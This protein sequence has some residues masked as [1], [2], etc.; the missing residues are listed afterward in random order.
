LPERSKAEFNILHW[1]KL[2]IPE[3]GRLLRYTG[4]QGL[5]WWDKDKATKVE[6]YTGIK[7][8]QYF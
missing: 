8:T 1:D 5:W 7:L 4:F 6:A 3:H 2:G